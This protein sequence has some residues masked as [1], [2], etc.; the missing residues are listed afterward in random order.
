MSSDACHLLS[1]PPLVL[2]KIL[3]HLEDPRWV[4]RAGRTCKQLA[5]L[6][7]QDVI[8][9]P[10]VRRDYPWIVNWVRCGGDH[11][12]RQAGLC[13]YLCSDADRVN[14]NKLL[15]YGSGIQG[16]IFKFKIFPR[17]QIILIFKKKL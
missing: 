9:R 5:S 1:L 13:G 11:Q 10:L 14:Y 6:V 12:T 4:V 16:N 3:Q 7:E 15:L 2:T 17:F 8:W